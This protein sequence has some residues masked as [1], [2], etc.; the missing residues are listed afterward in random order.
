MTKTILKSAL[1][2]LVTLGVVAP[3]VAGQLIVGPS[4]TIF[5]PG[6]DEDGNVSGFA[7]L[8]DEDAVVRHFKFTGS[9]V[10]FGFGRG[11]VTNL[12]GSRSVMRNLGLQVLDPEDGATI[13]IATADVASWSRRSG[14]GQS[15]YRQIALFIP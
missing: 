11:R 1:M 4:I 12:S 9:G 10:I 14:A 13:N 7:S 5:V 6:L 8:G 3:D 15:R 2:C